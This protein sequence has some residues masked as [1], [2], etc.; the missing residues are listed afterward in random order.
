MKTPKIII[1]LIIAFFAAYGGYALFQAESE[2]KKNPT[3]ESWKNTIPAACESG[4]WIDVSLNNNDAAKESFK[5]QVKLMAK[6]KK[7]SDESEKI[8]FSADD[9]EKLAYFAGKKVVVRGIKIDN[10]EVGVEKIKCIGAEADVEELSARRN[11]MN[12][13][14]RNINALA[15]KESLGGDWTVSGFYFVD[16]SNVYVEYEQASPIAGI[17][18]EK[19]TNDIYLW[20]VKISKLER[21]TPIIEGLSYPKKNNESVDIQNL[22]AYKF[23]NLK[24]QWK[25]Q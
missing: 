21:T 7:I 4:Q 15:P 9:E 13:I 22:S 19:K 14:S 3:T 12:Y 11:V 2:D 5:E 16:E 25:L 23:D 20:P 18:E 17:K 1:Y 8:S 10:D 6:G 24:K